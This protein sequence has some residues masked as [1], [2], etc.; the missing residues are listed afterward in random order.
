MST[1]LG[2][3]EL[4][5]KDFIISTLAL[6]D[7]TAAEIESEAPLFGSGLGLDSVEAL[8]LGVGLQKR[9]GVKL[10]PKDDSTREHFRS[11]HALACLVS[12]RRSA[13]VAK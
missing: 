12:E 13:V 4:E 9:F 6:E 1:D 5:L 3:L 7:I 2:L 8:E 10:D 11:V